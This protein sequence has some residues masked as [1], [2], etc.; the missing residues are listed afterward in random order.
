MRNM[1]RNLRGSGVQVLAVVAPSLTVLPGLP[2]QERK[3]ISLQSVG[4]QGVPNCLRVPASHTATLPAA[5]VPA[6]MKILQV[7]VVFRHGE[8]SFG[9][10]RNTV[11]P[12]YPLELPQD[13]DL[14]EPG[15]VR[16][17]NLGKQLRAAYADLIEPG[18]PGKEIYMFCCNPGDHRTRHWESLREILSGIWPNC[19]RRLEDLDVCV[20][21]LDGVTANERFQKTTAEQRARLS[22]VWTAWRTKHAAEES[23]AIANPAVKALVS[24]AT[25]HLGK[26]WHLGK[27]NGPMHILCIRLAYS[28]QHGEKMPTGVSH[29]DYLSIARACHQED[30]AIFSE[31]EAAQLYLGHFFG[32][33]L[34]EMRSSIEGNSSRKLFLYSSHDY[35]VGP[36]AAGLQAPFAAWPDVGSFVVIELLQHAASGEAFIRIIRNSVVVD[37]VLGLRTQPAGVLRFSDF[38]AKL[39]PR[40]LKQR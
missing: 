27:Q 18:G 14:T 32:D 12:S 36:L 37:S 26:K 22:Q 9:V 25:C 38:E 23:T 5:P 11:F 8:K 16:I 40:I 24:E 19:G 34:K 33:T 1:W 6:G 7:H 30:F 4:Q 35:C 17:R 20:P 2:L 15:R 3:S 21:G 10:E 29:Q 13:D 28:L 31:D 39:H